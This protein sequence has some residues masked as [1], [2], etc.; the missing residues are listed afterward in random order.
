MKKISIEN[1]TSKLTRQASI[2]RQVQKESREYKRKFNQ[3]RRIAQKYDAFI[4][5]SGNYFCVSLR[6]LEQIYIYDPDLTILLD[7]LNIKVQLTIW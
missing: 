3:V 4:S 5:F 2:D 7:D 6:N 1:L